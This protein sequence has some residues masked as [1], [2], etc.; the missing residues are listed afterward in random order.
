MSLKIDQKSIV[1]HESNLVQKFKGK[2]LKI[3]TDAKGK[4]WFSGKK[5]DILGS[6]DVND[7]LLKKSQKGAKIDLKLIEMAGEMPANSISYHDRK[8]V[9]IFEPGLYQLKFS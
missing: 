7:I 2:N 1:E 6:T 3:A 8:A 4:K 9:Y 5:C